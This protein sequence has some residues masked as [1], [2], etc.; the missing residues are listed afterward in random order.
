MSCSDLRV[1]LPFGRQSILRGLLKKGNHLVSLGL[2]RSDIFIFVLA[3]QFLLKW[4]CI[5][6]QI[7]DWII[8]RSNDLQWN[9]VLNLT[10]LP[11]KLLLCLIRLIVMFLWSAQHAKFAFAHRVQVGKELLDCT[12]H[13][14]LSARIITGDKSRVYCYDIE[15]KIQPLQWWVK[16]SPDRKNKFHPSSRWYQQFS[17]IKCVHR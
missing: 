3:M 2:H 4:N 11:L 1:K 6:W 12:E 15:I 8:W 16:H 10:N 7:S 5:I 9:F 13:E 14:N 17:S